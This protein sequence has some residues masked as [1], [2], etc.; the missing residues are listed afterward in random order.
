MFQR[1]KSSAA[2]AAPTYDAVLQKLQKLVRDFIREQDLPPAQNTF[3]DLFAD[4]DSLFSV[5][6]ILALEQAF[7]G[8]EISDEVSLTYPETEMSLSDMAVYIAGQL[9][10]K[11]GSGKP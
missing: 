5:E 2:D 11:S 10:A 6:F 8:I 4:E 9:N 7:P 1:A 3:A